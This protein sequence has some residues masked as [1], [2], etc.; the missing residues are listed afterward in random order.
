MPSISVVISEQKSVC[1]VRPSGYL[2]ETGGKE[3]LAAFNPPLQKGFKK[4]ILNL[5]GTP[6]INSQGITQILELG[7]MLMYDQKAVL[8]IVGLSELYLDVFQVVGI[9]KFAKILPNEETALK[10][11]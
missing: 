5:S 6:V 8:A 7:E 2:D 10:D 3:L 4:F 11:F 1:V 9:A